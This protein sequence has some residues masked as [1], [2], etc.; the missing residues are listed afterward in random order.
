MYHIPLYFDKIR[1]ITKGGDWM[2]VHKLDDETY[3]KL[4][5][6][7]D[8]EDLFQLVD[9]NRDYLRAWMPWIDMTQK[10]EDTKS[11]IESV[12]KKYA[13][14]DGFD[15]AIYHKGEVAG[16]I[17]LHQLNQSHK[18]TSI[19]Y[20]IGEEF[21]GKG[22]VTR[23]VYALLEY[24]FDTLEFHRVEIRCATENVKS[25]AIPERLGFTKE[26]V[27][28]DCEWLYD[29]YVSHVVYGMLKHEW[30]EKNVK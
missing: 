8:A 2:F 10:V 29:H 25:Q 21:Q 5:D 1:I 3:L 4:V 14:N 23:A 15:A 18:F 24:V 19:G 28:R 13:N 9:R 17:G 6:Y 26:G 16:T 11:F 22:I 7:H 12:M 27:I 30:D 20:W